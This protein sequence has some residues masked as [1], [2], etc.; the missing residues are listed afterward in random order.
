LQG[1]TDFRRGRRTR[2]RAIVAAAEL[3]EE[4]TF[5][6]RLR[7][8]TRRP[9]ADTPNAKAVLPRV[10][11]ALFREWTQ[12]P[13]PDHHHPGDAG[14]VQPHP[15]HVRKCCGSTGMLALDDAVKAGDPG[16]Q[17][18][19]PR[20]CHGLPGTASRL[21]GRALA[22]PRGNADPRPSGSNAT[23]SGSPISLGVRHLSGDFGFALGRCV[24]LVGRLSSPA[25]NMKRTHHCA[26]L[27]KADLGAVVSLAGW[28]I[29]PRPRAASF[30]STCATARESR[31][32]S[33]S[34]IP[35]PTPARA[36]RS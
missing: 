21:H 30:S 27:T 19:F 2:E 14:G 15:G 12:R 5:I 24:R 26:Q 33:W 10:P 20:L 7:T 25:S 22:E 9:V 18:T 3:E 1:E 28:V 4:T 11:V 13:S 17:R 35:T 36:P 32:S 29:H 8:R 34:P 6:T 23:S 31:R 16:A